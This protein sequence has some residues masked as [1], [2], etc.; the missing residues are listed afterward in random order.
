MTELPCKSLVISA[1][2]WSDRVF[3]QL[4]PNAKVKIPLNV[5]GAAG[6][7]MQIKNPRWNSSDDEAGVQQV[8]FNDV[9]PGSTGC[10][11][12]SFLGGSLYVGGY[13]AVPEPLPDKAEDVHVQSAAVPAMYELAADLVDTPAGR[14]LEI[15]DVGR[16]YRPLAVPRK[17]IITKID[18][19]ELG[20]SDPESCLL[21]NRC[22]AELDDKEGL[23]DIVQRPLQR[24]LGGLY[25]NTGHSSDGITLAPGSGKVMSE[26]ILGLPASVDISGLGLKSFQ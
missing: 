5:T 4:F 10:D 12:T 26:L 21:L 23:T 25:V 15:V 13:G 7:H 17:P 9:V 18:W 24:P 6:N 20:L 3:S 8:F 16:C 11:L 2:P 19:K 14:E 1:G 22:I